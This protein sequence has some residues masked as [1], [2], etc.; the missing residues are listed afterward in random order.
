M[1]VIDQ[2]F[3]IAPGEAIQPGD[4]VTID[5]G[6]G[7]LRRFVMGVDANG[8]RVPRGSYTDLETGE[9]CMPYRPAPLSPLRHENENEKVTPTVEM[10]QKSIRQRR[11]PTI[12]FTGALIAKTEFVIRGGRDMRFEIWQTEGGAL[13]PVSITDEET[14]AAIVEPGEEAA[15]RC[16]A[17]DFFDW[18]SRARE[19]V[20]DQLKW[21]LHIHVA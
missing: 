5:E 13:I 3:V 4:L 21:R 12:K 17:M 15:M 2:G 14:R 1:I 10:Q 18:D 20:K 8:F 9:L 6:T 11:G 7:K 16:A 19:M